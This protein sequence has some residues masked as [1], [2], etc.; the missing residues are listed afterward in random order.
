[1]YIGILLRKFKEKCRALYANNYLET[2]LQRFTNHFT[3]IVQNY[4]QKD[5]IVITRNLSEV[6]QNYTSITMVLDCFTVAESTVACKNVINNWASGMILQYSDMIL[7]ISKCDQKIQSTSSLK[8]VFINFFDYDDYGAQILS[9]CFV[10]LNGKGLFLIFD[11]VETSCEFN[12]FFS[13]ILNRVTLQECTLLVVSHPDWFSKNYSD[14]YL[15]IEL[16]PDFEP[17]IFINLLKILE[18][19][20]C[21]SLTSDPTKLNVEDFEKDTSKFNSLPSKY[22]AIIEELSLFS[23][24]ALKFDKFTFS[25]FEIN[26]GLSSAEIFL[27]GIL[28]ENDVKNSY[29]F[30]HMYLQEYLAAYYIFLLDEDKQIVVLNEIIWNKT[31]RGLCSTYISIC[32]IN[33]SNCFQHYIS[34]FL[35][36]LNSSVTI[37]IQDR[38]KFLVL[39]H[40][41]S[42]APINVV[43][44]VM[45]ASHSLDLNGL[46]LS[47]GDIQ[48][49]SH[50][51]LTLH[52]ICILNLSDCFIDDQKF[53]IFIKH[54][55]Q[56]HGCEVMQ[57][58]SI[59]TVNLSH[60]KLTSLSIDRLSRLTEVS[61]IE[62][63]NVSYNYL[64]D[65]HITSLV[66]S[67]SILTTL[68]LSG[69]Q[70]DLTKMIRIALLLREN[71]KLQKLNICNNAEL[72]CTDAEFIVDVILSVNSMLSELIINDT[73]IRPRFS[74]Y[75]NILS[76]NIGKFFSLQHLYIANKFPL[77][78]SRSYMF[79]D[80]FITSLD[81]NKKFAEVKETCPF[82]DS[83][84]FTH[85]VDHKGGVYHYKDHDIELFIPPGAILQDEWVEIKVS[86]SFHGQF[87]MPENYNRISSYVWV[88]ASYDFKVPVY[89]VIN[90]FVNMK[91]V[92]DIKTLTAFEACKVYGSN[93]NETTAMQEIS[94]KCFDTALK[95]CVIC[96][97]HH[98]C[99]YCLAELQ[100]SSNEDCNSH[101]EFLSI[102]YNYEKVKPNKGITYFYAEICCLYFNKNCFKVGIYIYIIYH[103]HYFFHRTLFS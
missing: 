41:L 11:H 35:N 90:H 23:F 15:K 64:G 55:L 67:S 22:E 8:D 89:L 84:I 74:N 5:S 95:Y 31:Y 4:K 53:R 17:S 52:E 40:L 82:D 33:K 79:E 98:F 54:I 45:K 73:N 88:G 91:S 34:I 86:S 6:F 76:N 25:K 63:L 77:Y 9:E 93:N 71:V 24:K 81:G 72:F 57:I 37:S 16:V 30:A 103:N 59:H 18:K 65:G 36:S 1:M 78:L 61:K 2:L 43:T 83:T 42:R 48:A 49:I 80:N 68:D 38:E 39:L 28:K 14:D 19:Y 66:E 62:T 92:K 29:E 96:A 99:T 75:S 94:T 46:I 10:N 7:Y 47:Y 20:I 60:N 70:I 13:D 58:P 100:T 102:Y 87:H 44:E 97:D 21:L 27:K 50:C 12:D 85:Y 101:K 3:F 51:L 26:I 32:A 69:N 56:N